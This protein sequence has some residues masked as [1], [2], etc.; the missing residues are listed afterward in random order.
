[1]AYRELCDSTSLELV[2]VSSKLD[3]NTEDKPLTAVKPVK[4]SPVQKLL[5]G[6]LVISLRVG[7]VLSAVVL[8][9]NVIWLSYALANYGVRDGLGI[10]S[11]GS[12]QSLKGLDI[13]LHL[14][15]NVLSTCLQSATNMHV[16]AFSSPSR[17]EVDSAHQA[18]HW[19]HLGV[20]SIRNLPRIARGKAGLVLF[21]LVS[22]VC[23]SPSLQSYCR[24]RINC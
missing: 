7:T 8:L 9:T 24:R 1:M 2:S 6:G 23:V 19:L 4:S 13:W 22:C 16:A 10:I 15:I 14:L 21:L 20:F 12:C 3:G 5:D 17:Q 18:Q 11:R